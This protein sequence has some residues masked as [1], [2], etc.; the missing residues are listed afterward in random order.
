MTSRQGELGALYLQEEF[1]RDFFCGEASQDLRTGL[2]RDLLEHGAVNGS[3]IPVL[4][5][6]SRIWI[7]SQRFTLGFSCLAYNRQP[8]SLLLAFSHVVD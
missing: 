3:G 8:R 4:W 7:S 5:L 1:L 6:E 2:T